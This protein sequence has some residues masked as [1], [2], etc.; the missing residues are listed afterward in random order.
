MPSDPALIEIPLFPLATVLFPGGQ[1]NLRIFEPR[2]LDMIKTCSRTGQFFGICL[3]LEG[4]ETGLPAAPAAIGTFAEILDFRMGED[5][6]LQ[7]LVAGRQRFRVE[8]T[9]IRS[10]GL[11]LAR[12]QAWSESSPL[13]V[14][15]EYSVLQQIAGRLL[16][17]VDEPAAEHPHADL[18]D[19]E[20]LGYRLAQW[21]PLSDGER[22][23]LLEQTEPLQRLHELTCLLP[24]FQK[25]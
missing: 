4:E 1:L 19:A 8:Q 5:G 23:Q 22:Q 9:R 15:V 11:I 18:D 17:V 25:D 20:R 24:R 7:I 14:P 16:E 2:Y 10:D 12:V 13:A 6:L 3:I 21:L